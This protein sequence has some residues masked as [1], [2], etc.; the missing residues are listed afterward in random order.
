MFDFL[1]G[2]SPAVAEAA[3][4]AAAAGEEV[5]EVNPVI[6][7]L[8]TFAPMILIFVVFYFILIRPQRKKDKQ[9][10]R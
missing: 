4:E 2:I 9:R 5:A 8:V 10:G 7:M 6:S 3:T 1:F